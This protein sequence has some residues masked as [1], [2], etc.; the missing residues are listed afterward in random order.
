MKG[1]AMA[2]KA[3]GKDDS[4]AIAAAVEFHPAANIF[5]LDDEHIDELARDIKANGLRLPIVTLD[6]KIL[7]GRRRFMACRIAGVTPR[8]EQSDTD[9]PVAFVLSLNLHRRHLTVSQAAM[10][11]ARARDLYAKQAKERQRLSDGRGKKGSTKCSDLSGEGKA[12]EAVGLVFGVSGGSVDR[13]RRVIENGLP[14]LV[15]AVDAG[16]VTVA[17]A[18]AISRHAPEFQRDLLMAEANT[19]QKASPKAKPA[20]EE[21]PEGQ[22]RGVGVTLANEAINCL[23]RI[24]KNDRLRKRGF[25]IVTDWIRHN[26]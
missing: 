2:R 23:I 6:E 26:K 10:C 17:K 19:L 25:Q 22:P 14:E 8:F 24:P 13:A 20:E 7:D 1:R 11:A 5:P 15:E 12:S 21:L 16:K 4:G 18:A 3:D 9:D